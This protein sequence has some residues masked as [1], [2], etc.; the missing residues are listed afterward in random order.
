MCYISHWKAYIFLF[1]RPIVDYLLLLLMMCIPNLTAYSNKRISLFG[2]YF[3]HTRV[4]PI[5]FSWINIKR[6][7]I[8]HFFWTWRRWPCREQCLI[9]SSMAFK[10]S[11]LVYYVAPFRSLFTKLLFHIEMDYHNITLSFIK[12]C[13][14]Y[15]K[16][17]IEYVTTNYCITHYLH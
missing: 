17:L 1:I 11:F 13:T 7:R 14:M 9:P 12:K 6:I 15:H 3:I 4:N 8:Y 10:P 16:L 2:Q 5:E